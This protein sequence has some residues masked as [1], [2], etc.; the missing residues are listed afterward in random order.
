MD[1]F[2]IQFFPQIFCVKYFSSD[3]SS[4]QRT[5]LYTLRLKVF[6]CIHL[7][8]A[9]IRKKSKFEMFGVVKMSPYNRMAP[10]PSPIFF[11]FLFYLNLSLTNYPERVNRFKSVNIRKNVRRIVFCTNQTARYWIRY[12]TD[13]TD[14]KIRAII[15][16]NFLL[17]SW[18]LHG[19]QVSGTT[20]VDLS[21]VVYLQHDVFC[22][23]FFFFVRRCIRT[24]SD[25]G[26]NTY[27]L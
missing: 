3:I 18:C 19:L 25:R 7:Q 15:R 24:A 21:A 14:L 11:Y 17:C 27:G 8:I 5:V 16:L 6:F 9:N 23:V 2:F 13:V 12:G 22:A 26:E 10:K 1:F 20:D 4:K